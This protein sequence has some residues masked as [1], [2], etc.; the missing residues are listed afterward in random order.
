M[1]PTRLI[2]TTE[3]IDPVFMFIFGACLVLLVGITAAMAFFVVRYHRSRAPQ[4]TSQVESSLWLE[5]VWTLLPT[6]LVLAMF[7]YG[8]KEYLVLRTVP[9][10][11]LEV[12]ATAR[13]WSWSFSY[14]NGTTS[15]NLYVPVGRPIKVNLVSQD[16]IHGF[17]LPAFRVKRDVVPGMKNYAWFVA[18]KTGSYDL[19]C[20][21][22][23]GTNH[24][25]MITTVEALPAA[26]FAEWLEHGPGGGGNK[27]SRID[28]KKLAQEKGCLGCHSLDGSP[29][30]GPSFKG[31]SGRSTV[32]VTKGAERTIT[33]DDAYLRQSILD[34]HADVVKGF[35]AIMPAFSDLSKDEVS[36]LVEYLEEI[37]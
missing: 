9:K 32:V 4:P 14:P 35:Q 29:G 2:S 8:W 31:I 27:E 33:V 17:F 12:T 7:W 11:A 3:A 10:G 19:F 20:S 37:K 5:I 15:P 30:V 13:Q 25:A 1:D 23:C 6:I 28:G 21:Q 16:V 26:E 24:S 34:P 22:Y 36:A 18:S